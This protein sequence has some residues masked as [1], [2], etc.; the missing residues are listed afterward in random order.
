MWLVVS[1][2]FGCNQKCQA[3]CKPTDST[4]GQFDVCLTQAMQSFSTQNERKRPPLW[5]FP[6]SSSVKLQR[7][8]S[9]PDANDAYFT[10]SSHH[11]EGCAQKLAREG[12]L[13]FESGVQGIKSAVQEVRER[14]LGAAADLA[15]GVGLGMGMAKAFE[16]LGPASLAAISLKTILPLSAGVSLAQDAI[17]AGLAMRD[18]WQTGANFDKDKTAV[19]K[20]FSSLAFNSTL[21]AAGS[22]AGPAIRFSSDAL[23]VGRYAGLSAIDRSS[24]RLM[25]DDLAGSVRKKQPAV[26]EIFTSKKGSNYNGS[27]FFVSKDGLVATSNHVIEDTDWMLLARKGFKPMKAKVVASWPTHDLAILKAELPA[28]TETVP[29]LRIASQTPSLKEKLASMGYPADSDDLL[30]LT[31]SVGRNLN[32]SESVAIQRFGPE[33]ELKRVAS[34]GM[35]VGKIDANLTGGMSGGP[36]VDRTGAA[37][38]VN[39]GGV[40]PGHKGPGE[41]VSS[42]HLSELLAQIHP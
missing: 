18:C 23:K 37:V 12:Q 8:T 39:L 30:N 5:S 11:Q 17:P 3:R 24:L 9:V 15:A 41:F 1:V 27:G 22:F 20:A 29:F 28:G 40:I 42:K 2:T 34:G 26:V 35:T 32:P 25:T 38:G 19:T 13:L 36:V 16:S 14:P 21:M 10:P 31:V 33:Y 4:Y 6:E 7:V